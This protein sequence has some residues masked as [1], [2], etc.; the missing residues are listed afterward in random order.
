MGIGQTLTLFV[1][2]GTIV[3][4][5]MA[6]LVTYFKFRKITKKARTAISLEEINKNKTIHKEV[7]NA[8]EESRREDE[9]NS[10]GINNNL[11]KAERNASEQ[12]DGN[13]ELDGS[14]Q[15][16]GNVDGERVPLPEPS[17]DEPPKPTPRRDDKSVDEAWEA[18]DKE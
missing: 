9:S 1:V 13:R 6:L 7:E 10:G 4:L 2:A 16:E 14:V 12:V 17:S 15:A 8:R 18:L 11:N 5:L 3:A